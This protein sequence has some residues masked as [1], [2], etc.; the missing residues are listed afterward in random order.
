MHRGWDGGETREGFRT[1]VG[2][3]QA[4]HGIVHRVGA[5]LLLHLSASNFI[6]RRHQ[7]CMVYGITLP[8]RLR[9][10]VCVVKGRGWI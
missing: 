9:F 8:S 4:P 3:T 10:V 7:F 5:P 6:A 2:I 1:T